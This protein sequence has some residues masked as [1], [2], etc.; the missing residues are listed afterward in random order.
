MYCWKEIMFEEANT[1]SNV[2]LARRCAQLRQLSRLDK[3]K[4]F[5]SVCG[6]EWGK[7]DVVKHFLEQDDV[8]PVI[9]DEGNYAI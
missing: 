3:L 2:S 8:E 6:K 4:R 9:F 7:C 5:C 1:N